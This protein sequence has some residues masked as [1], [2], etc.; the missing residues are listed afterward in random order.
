MLGS[1]G[2]RLRP[3]LSRRVDDAADGRKVRDRDVASLAQQNRRIGA[4]EKEKEG[5][6]GQ[7]LCR[8]MLSGR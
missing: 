3:W 2:A 4:V 5:Y 7:L 8:I 6:T 1:P